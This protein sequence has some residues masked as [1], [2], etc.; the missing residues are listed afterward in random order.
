[1]LLWRPFGCYQSALLN[2]EVLL[3]CRPAFGRHLDDARCSGATYPSLVAKKLRELHA[4]RAGKMVLPFRR[5][6][7]LPC[8][9]APG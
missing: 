2:T 6:E 3:E 1:M 4:E 8:K 7:A 5:V 9:A